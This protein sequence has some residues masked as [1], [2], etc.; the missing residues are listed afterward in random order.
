MEGPTNK[1]IILSIARKLAVKLTLIAAL[2]S[3]SVV[4][5][6]QGRFWGRLGNGDTVWLWCSPGGN[7][8]TRCDTGS[9]PTGQSCPCYECTTSDCQASANYWCASGG[10]PCPDCAALEEGPVN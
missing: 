7:H 9:C 2:L 3:A 10:N 5:Y 8:W 6:G 1:L 4:V